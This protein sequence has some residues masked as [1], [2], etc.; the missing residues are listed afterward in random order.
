MKKETLFPLNMALVRA[1]RQG[2]NIFPSCQAGGAC[3]Q[4][5]FSY[6]LHNIFSRFHFNTEQKPILFDLCVVLL[7]VQAPKVIHMRDYV[8]HHH[9]HHLL[10]IVASDMP[11]VL[12]QNAKTTV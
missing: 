1:D 6:L 9:H 8:L 4:A 7:D 5:P 2:S 12:K 11:P 10:N 3:K